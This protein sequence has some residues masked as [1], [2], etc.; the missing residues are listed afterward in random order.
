MPWTQNHQLRLHNNNSQHLHQL[1]QQLIK[2][3]FHENL[4]SN[5]INNLNK[6]RHHYK[7]QCFHPWVK[8]FKIRIKRVMVLAKA[9]KRNNR[10]VLLLTVDPLITTHLRKIIFLHLSH[11]LLLEMYHDFLRKLPLKRQ[12]LSQ[13]RVKKK[14]YWLNHALL[15]DSTEVIH[16][17]LFTKISWEIW[18]KATNASTSTSQMSKK[19]T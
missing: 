4:L 13:C 15:L 14:L 10:L 12:T 3:Q 11:L 17:K 1:K 16:Q 19:K 6:N 9:V 2:I 8:I 7:K 5:N 18:L